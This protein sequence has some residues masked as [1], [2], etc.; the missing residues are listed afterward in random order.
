MALLSRSSIYKRLFCWTPCIKSANVPM[1]FGWCSLSQPSRTLFPG[2]KPVLYTLLST[3]VIL[4]QGRF[5][6]VNHDHYLECNYSISTSD[7]MIFFTFLKAGWYYP[8]KIFCRNISNL[9][10]NKVPLLDS[11][12]IN[13]LRLNGTS[14]LS[15]SYLFRNSTQSIFFRIKLSNLCYKSLFNIPSLQRKV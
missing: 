13:I 6:L 3:T 4:T 12:F 9:V 14:V 2:S 11:V 7:V 5:G 8:S 15:S 10:N 1:V